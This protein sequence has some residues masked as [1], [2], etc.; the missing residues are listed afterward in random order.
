MTVMREGI[1]KTREL[2]RY[3]I[4]QARCGLTVRFVC[5]GVVTSRD[6]FNLAVERVQHVPGVR[7]CPT[8]GSKAIGFASGGVVSFV[9]GAS[10]DVS[11]AGIDIEVVDRQPVFE[12]AAVA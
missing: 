2:V 6:A 12:T 4:E 1:D 9:S 7:V 10:R 5:A 11:R 8:A 3:A